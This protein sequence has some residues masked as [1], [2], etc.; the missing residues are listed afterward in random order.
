MDLLRLPDNWRSITGGAIVR[1]LIN[2]REAFDKQSRIGRHLA[3]A[4]LDVMLA[5]H[6][7]PEGRAIRVVEETDER[8]RIRDFVYLYVSNT[9]VRLARLLKGVPAHTQVRLISL[10]N[11]VESIQR[12]AEALWPNADVISP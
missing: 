6:R 3:R 8:W 9:R 10:P 4:T 11:S 7:S 1:H 2:E 12:R 5:T